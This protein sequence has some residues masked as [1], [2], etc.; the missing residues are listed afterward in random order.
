MTAPATI[1]EVLEKAADLLEPEGRW[2]QHAYGRWNGSGYSCWC[3]FGAIDAIASDYKIGAQC[4]NV[5]DRVVGQGLVDWNDAPGRT[6]PE[7]V[8]ALRRAAALAREQ[9]A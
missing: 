6:Q 2:T 8:A 3:M 5:V 7:V 4:N 1:A 9:G